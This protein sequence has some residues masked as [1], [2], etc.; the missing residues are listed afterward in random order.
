MISKTERNIIIAITLI[1]FTWWFIIFPFAKDTDQF[2]NLHPLIQY[3]LVN[4]AWLTLFTLIMGT[5]I[6]MLKK[7]DIELQTMLISGIAITLTFGLVVDMIMPPYAWGF[8]GTELITP[9]KEN[10][11]KASTDYAIGYTFGSLGVPQSNELFGF[12]YSLLWLFTYV[13]TPILSVVL[14]AVVLT[15]DKLF[16]LVKSG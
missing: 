5:M 3:I 15:G 8:E 14:A 6:S 1:A 2:Y 10:L 13:F 16:R 12:R 4:I 9:T 11:L 7:G